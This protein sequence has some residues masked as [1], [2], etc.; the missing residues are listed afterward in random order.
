MG[1]FDQFSDVRILSS[2]SQIGGSFFLG[3]KKPKQSESLFPID[4]MFWRAI[5]DSVINRKI[6]RD[7]KKARLQLVSALLKL[8]WFCRILL[9]SVA[10]QQLHLTVGFS[11]LNIPSGTPS[12]LSLHNFSIIKAPLCG[13]KHPRNIRKVWI[14]S[15]E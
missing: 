4:A 15:T 13:S 8:H 10:G 1:N 6:R 9:P 2:D 12:E 14:L 11:D 7:A 5:N 3:N